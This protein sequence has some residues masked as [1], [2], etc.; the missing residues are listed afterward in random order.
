MIGT[1][2]DAV[3]VL[4]VPRRWVRPMRAGRS[5]LQSLQMVGAGS[6]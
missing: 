3:L 1:I 6:C 4:V 2:A 5:A